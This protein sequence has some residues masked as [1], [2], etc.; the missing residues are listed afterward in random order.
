[1]YTDSG[2]NRRIY[3]EVTFRGE[4]SANQFSFK[5]SMS[6]ARVTVERMLQEVKQ[7]W[8]AVYMNNKLR[9]GPFP[10]GTL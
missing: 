9:I 10:V 4:L 7:Y 6:V 1:M 2:Y 5:K 3:L 8:G